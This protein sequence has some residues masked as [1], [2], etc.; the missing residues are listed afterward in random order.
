MSCINLKTEKNVR[1]RNGRGA[2]PNKFTLKSKH[3]KN[4]KSPKPFL[5]LTF[6]LRLSHSF[7]TLVLLLNLLLVA[8]AAFDLISDSSQLCAL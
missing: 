7:S 5:S 3:V 6:A 4:I 1:K 8:H 2:H